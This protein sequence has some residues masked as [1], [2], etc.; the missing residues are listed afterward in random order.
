M[1]VLTFKYGK[2]LTNSTPFVPG[3][4]YLDV[5]TGEFWFDDPTSEK[6]EHQKIIDVD[7]IMYK[8]DK[9]VEWGSGTTIGGATAKLGSAI[10]GTMVLGTE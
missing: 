8:I 2:G 10:L 4:V 7:T 9:T 6:T 5:E 1:A 3:T